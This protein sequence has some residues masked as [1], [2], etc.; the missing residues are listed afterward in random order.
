MKEMFNILIRHNMTPNRFYVLWSMKEQV[1]TPY[2]NTDLELKL[3]KRD[4]YVLENNKI[5][6]EGKS[7]IKEVEAY[8]KIIKS[9]TSAKIMGEDF[10]K[11]METYN[12]IF[13][14]IRYKQT[15][16]RARSAISNIEP[17]FRWFF[18]NHDYEWE[19]IFAATKMYIKE[20]RQVNWDYARTSQYF[21]RKQQPDKTWESP[22]ADFCESI[23]SGE[24]DMNTNHFKEKVF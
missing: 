3:L 2:V 13:P 4:G 22:L 24:E 12:E 8:F 15:K 16:K 19:T 9:K 23:L 1:T 14:N 7:L 10:K 17:A 18:K 5:S 21:I 11:N 20:K 6:S